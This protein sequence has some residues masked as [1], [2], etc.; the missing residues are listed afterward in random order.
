MAGFW[1]PDAQFGGL[2]GVV[3]TRV[4]YTGGRKANP[5]YRSLG[6]HTETVEVDFDPSIISYEQLLIHFWSMHRPT[7]RPYSEQY[8]SAI[9]VQ[10]EQQSAIAELSKL[11]ASKQLGPIYTDILP[12]Q[13]FYWAED[14]HQKYMLRSYRNIESEFKQMY[15]NLKDFVNSTAVTRANAFVAGYGDPSFTNELVPQ[16]GLTEKSQNSLLNQSR[17][18]L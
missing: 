11:R 2:P 13:T 8:K 5:T 12:A 9:F 18:Y 3:R 15:P 17:R 6:N 1:G 4:G 7:R 10:N 14:Y 16:L